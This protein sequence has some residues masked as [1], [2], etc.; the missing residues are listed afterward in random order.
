LRQVGT[1]RGIYLAG[2]GLGLLV[3]GQTRL[4]DLE[5]GAKF[6]AEKAFVLLSGQ[7]LGGLAWYWRF[8][9]EGGEGED[10]GIR[11]RE[12]VGDDEQ[13]TDPTPSYPG[14]EMG[15]PD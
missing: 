12:D 15:S 2:A 7:K 8:M 4:E 13:E 1:D 3:G 11:E 5:I 6:A 10:G 14:L 9:C